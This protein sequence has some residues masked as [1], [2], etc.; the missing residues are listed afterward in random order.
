MRYLLLFRGRSRRLVGGL[1]L[2]LAFALLAFA[3]GLLA[4]ALGLLR[5]GL[6]FGLRRVALRRIGL[7]RSRSGLR[8]VLGGVLRRGGLRKRA[9]GG[10]RENRGDQRGQQLAHV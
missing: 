6:L 1:A 9:G 10:N 4:F 7:R 3:L 2:G 5:L 8:G